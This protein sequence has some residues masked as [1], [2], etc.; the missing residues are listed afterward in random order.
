M[1]FSAVILLPPHVF[2]GDDRRRREERDREGILPAPELDGSW[3]SPAAFT[4]AFLSAHRAAPA[5][6]ANYSGRGFR[7]S[8]APSSSPTNV[9]HG[10]TA[11]TKASLSLGL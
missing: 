10:Q 1:G 4:S 5:S 8:A 6:L 2:Q 9:S 7:E 11:C 3:N